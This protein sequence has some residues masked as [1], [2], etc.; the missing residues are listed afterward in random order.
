MC[1]PTHTSTTSASGEILAIE[2][3]ATDSELAEAVRRHDRQAFEHL[4][5]RYAP[6]VY[7]IAHRVLRRDCDAEAVVSD[8][9]YELWTGPNK[10]D[11]SKQSLHTFFIVMAR[12]RS[13]DRLRRESTLQ[14]HTQRAAVTSG[15]GAAPTIDPDRAMI[16]REQTDMTTEA[17]AVLDDQQAVAIRLAFFAGLTHQQIA[18]ELGEPLGTIKSRIR[19]GLQRLKSIL[20]RRGVDGDEA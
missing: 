5:D 13:I 14:I 16:R 15:T 8:V 9:F 11:P 4:Y 18:I 10:I 3:H 19:S 7:G 2:E 1:P 17:L 20:R 12:S 6:L